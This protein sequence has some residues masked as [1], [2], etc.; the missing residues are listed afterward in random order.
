M[1]VCKKC[2]KEKIDED[3]SKG[4]AVCKKCCYEKYK[5]WAQKNKDKIKSNSEKW[6]T[7][8]RK[9]ARKRCLDHYYN[10]KYKYKLYKLEN[11]EKNI[12][13]SEK[14][15]ENNREKIRE[16]CRELAK[17]YRLERPQ[18]HKARKSVYQAIKKGTLTRMENCMICGKSCKT[19][20]H[21]NDYSKPLSVIWVCPRC[22]GGIHSNL[23]ERKK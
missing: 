5:E 10:N 8:N 22:H 12:K 14:Y 20:A 17:K 16:R 9:I 6:R 13:Y 23:N 3:F 1:K 7:K 4:R 21:H 2:K 15:R 18:E 19:Q 11:K